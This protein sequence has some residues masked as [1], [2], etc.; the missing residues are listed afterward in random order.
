MEKKS[1]MNFLNQVA[2]DYGFD[3]FN[4]AWHKG[5]NLKCDSIV[6]EA[7]KR[8]V[9]QYLE[10]SA[11]NAMIRTRDMEGNTIGL[12]AKTI[13]EDHLYHEVVKTSI[14]LIEIDV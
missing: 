7:G 9:R 10:V 8:Y 6:K 4:N 1:L 11:E 5:S 13:Y 12:M 2:K 14:T 3:S